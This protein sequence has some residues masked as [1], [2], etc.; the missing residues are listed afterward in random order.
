TVRVRSGRMAES[1]RWQVSLSNI[2]AWPVALAF[3]LAMSFAF[4]S[5]GF[6]AIR[7]GF[8]LEI[9]ALLLT[10]HRQ[11][12]SLVP[13][14]FI[15]HA[16]VEVWHG[17]AMPIA[18]GSAASAAMLAFAAAHILRRD[19]KWLDGRSDTAAAWLRFILVATMLVPAIDALWGLFLT[20]TAAPKAPA[21]AG[22]L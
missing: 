3:S 8:G 16:A 19:E 20:A 13:A 10:P 6:P 12:R 9:A 17:G 21:A 11:W 2:L 22:A 18:I 1:A 4:A 7:L 15:T 5:L 14:F